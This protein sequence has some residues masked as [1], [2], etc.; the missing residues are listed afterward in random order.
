MLRAIMADATYLVVL[1]TCP[2]DRAPELARSLVEARLAACVNILPAVRSLYAWKGEV[3]D[4]AEA[5]L[6]VKTRASLFEALRAAILA[7]HPYEVPEIIAL[8]V[9]AG[10]QPYLDWLEG[11]TRNP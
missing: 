7:G 9:V 5:L 11:S 10:H 6:V 3:C 1:V 2:P 8:P 4:D